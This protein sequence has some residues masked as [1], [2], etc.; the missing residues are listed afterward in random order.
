MKNI[1]LKMKKKCYLLKSKMLLF[2]IKIV[3]QTI[4]F[5]K[6][7]KISQPQKVKPMSQNKKILKTNLLKTKLSKFYQRN[8]SVG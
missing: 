5:N 7:D 4:K 2:I 6:F 1:L 8:H 3:L